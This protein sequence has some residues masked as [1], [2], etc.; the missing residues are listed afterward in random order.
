MNEF[1]I[2][3]VLFMLVLSIIAALIIISLVV[4]R[5]FNN[6]NR[7]YRTYKPKYYKRYRG[8]K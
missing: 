6:L 7:R 3:T 5:G 1:A 4:P 2:I 8:R